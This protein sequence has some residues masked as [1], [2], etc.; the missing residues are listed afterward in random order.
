MSTATKHLRRSNIVPTGPVAQRELASVLGHVIGLDDT[1]LNEIDA[2]VRISLSKQRIAWSVIA[3]TAQYSHLASC[4]WVK[5][6][7]QVGRV[8]SAV[9]RRR[10]QHRFVWSAR[11][12]KGCSHRTIEQQFSGCRN[13][14]ARFR[15]CL[16]SVRCIAQTYQPMPNLGSN[17]LTAHH[18]ASTQTRRRRPPAAETF[19]HLGSDP[20]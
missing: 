9:R 18:P 15:S 8:D 5:A 6:Q 19:G 20:T 1:C 4:R 3:R 11:I 12:A 10:K 7:Q 14:R 16:E 2:V 13:G 17:T